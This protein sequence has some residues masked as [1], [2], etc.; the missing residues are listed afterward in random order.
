M[1]NLNVTHIPVVTN[2]KKLIGIVTS[3]DLSKAIATNSNDL[4]RN[5]DKNS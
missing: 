1:F 2:G 4:K 5:N 3:W